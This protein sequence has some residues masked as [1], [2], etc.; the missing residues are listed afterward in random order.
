M[1]RKKILPPLI[2]F[3]VGLIF[4]LPFFGVPF[5]R[6]PDAVEF[7][8]VARNIVSGKGLI[9][10]IKWNFFE[11]TPV[12]TSAFHGKPFFVSLIFSVILRLQNDPYLLQLFLLILGAANVVLFYFL[13]RKFLSE[14]FS[15][16]VSLLFA[17]NP[18]ILITNRMVLSDEVFYFFVL[19]AFLLFFGKDNL[20]KYIFLGIVSAFAYLTRAE[21]T[22]LFLAIL[23]TYIFQKKKLLQISL[24][25]GF[26]ILTAFPYFLGNA[27]VNGSPFFNYN[28]YHFKVFNFYDSM[29]TGYG[30]TY[31][32]SI[33]F[34]Q[35]NFLW[36]LN[37]IWQA[38][39]T[40]VK[41][42]VGL[43]FFGPLTLL[44]IFYKNFSRK[45]LP[46]LFFISAIFLTFSVTWAIFSEPERHLVMVF[47]LGLIPL[48]ALV[49]GK[50]T[51][52][53]FF[54]LVVLL[55]LVVYL[56]FD[57]H[58]IVWSRTVEGQ[59][60]AWNYQTRKTTYD[61]LKNHTSQ[62]SIVASTN[63]WMITLFAMRPSIMLGTN[64]D[65]KNYCKFIS[66]YK[67]SY[68][69]TSDA[70]LEKTLDREARLVLKDQSFLL[71]KTPVC[72]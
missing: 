16:V 10:T 68:L 5:W 38:I 54:I 4:R 51:R 61:Y 33:D 23:V 44:A 48:F 50:Y 63:P 15:I 67:I 39:I 29:F 69:L 30:R 12:I 7:I 66:Q 3:L 37:A 58:R 21:G 31:P 9:Q 45:F 46:I 19:T 49:K 34:I 8:D 55:M 72:K 57:I 47:A 18:N 20:K 2:L 40:N 62:N 36:I 1:E 22:F 27:I 35:K 65:N 53:P 43:T 11:S 17:L 32:S 14:K 24:F 26:F 25:A 28:S 64:I 6:T 41:S 60:D 59:T 56:G 71:F 42:L 13:A 70:N 52:D